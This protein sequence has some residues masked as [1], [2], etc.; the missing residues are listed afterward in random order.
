MKWPNS[1]GES[2]PGKSRRGGP[3]AS[4]LPVPMKW[5]PERVDKQVFALE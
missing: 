3:H 5:Y 2:W 1:I 4:R